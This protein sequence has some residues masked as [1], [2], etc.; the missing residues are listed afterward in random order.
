MRLAPGAIPFLRKACSTKELHVQQ[1]VATIKSTAIT[2]DDEKRDE[3]NRI[4]DIPGSPSS[5]ETR[6]STI[7]DTLSRSKPTSAYRRGP[8]ASELASETQEL[9]ESKLSPRNQEL[10]RLH[11]ATGG[12]SSSALSSSKSTLTALWSNIATSISS[13]FPSGWRDSFKNNAT[14]KTPAAQDSSTHEIN[15]SYPEKSGDQVEQ[16]FKDP[17]Q[18]VGDNEVWTFTFL[19][20]LI[21]PGP[22]LS[23]GPD[24]QSSNSNSN[25]SSSVSHDHDKHSTTSTSEPVMYA[26]TAIH[27]PPATSASRRRLISLDDD[28]ASPFNTQ[29]HALPPFSPRARTGSQQPRRRIGGSKLS[30]TMGDISHSHLSEP[31]TQSGDSQGVTHVTPSTPSF[32]RDSALAQVEALMST[33]SSVLTK[34]ETKGLQESS[35]ANRGTAV[36]PSLLLQYSRGSTSY[37]SSSSD[38]I[39]GARRSKAGSSGAGIRIQGPS[40][41]KSLNPWISESQDGDLLDANAAFEA[42]KIEEEH[43][44]RTAPR[45]GL[46]SRRSAKPREVGAATPLAALLRRRQRLREEAEQLEEQQNLD[47]IEAL[48]KE[49]EAILAADRQQVAAAAAAAAALHP[50]GDLRSDA[51]V[52][53]SL[54]QSSS[55]QDAVPHVDHQQADASTLHPPSGQRSI[56]EAM[57][58]FRAAL[59]ARPAPQSSTAPPAAKRRQRQVTA[60]VSLPH[61]GLEHGFGSAVAAG[62]AKPSSSQPEVSL[63]SGE[64]SMDEL[65]DMLDPTSTS[66]IQAAGAEVPGNAFFMDAQQQVPSSSSSSSSSMMYGDYNVNA[67]KA[68]RPY[69]DRRYDDNDASGRRYEKYEP[70]KR[71]PVLGSWMKGLQKKLSQTRHSDSSEGPSGG[72]NIISPESGNRDDQVWDKPDKFR[73]NEFDGSMVSSDDSRRSSRGRL[74]GEPRLSS[75]NGALPNFNNPDQVIIPSGTTLR[76]L[77]QLLN[78]SMDELEA[79]LTEQLGMSF[80]SHEEVV[81]QEAAELAAMEWGRIAIL[82]QGEDEARYPP[83]ARPPVVT[84]MGHVDHGKTSLLDALRNSN[85]AAS[86]AGGITQ[87]I[88]AFEV[89]LKNTSSGLAVGL[90]TSQQQSIGSSTPEDAS[91]PSTMAQPSDVITFLDTPGHAAFSS[92]RA[93]GAAL[94]DIVVLVVAADDGV[95]PQTREALAHARSAGCPLVVALTKCDLPQA[96][97]E[98]V[99][100]QLLEEGVELEEQGGTVQLVRT[101]AVSGLG[102][103]DLQEAL[104]LQAEIMELQSA[105]EGPATASVVEARLD[106]GAGAVATVVVRSG[107][108][109]V[110]DP[111]VVGT[112]WGRVRALKSGSGE[113]LEVVGPGRHAL[114]IGLKGLPMAGDELSVMGSEQRARSVALARAERAEDFRAARMAGSLHVQRMK[115]R[116]A[117][118]EATE[119]RRLLR[120][121]M[122]ALLVQNKQRTAQKLAALSEELR[123]KTSSSSTATISATSPQDSGDYVS[124]AAAAAS[125]VEGTAHRSASSDSVQKPPA[126][127]PDLIETEVP[128]VIKAD[129]QGSVE[130]LINA[131]KNL[132]IPGVSPRVLLSGVG[133]LTMSDVN[134][135][136]ASGA[137]II[138][139][140]QQSFQSKAVEASVQDLKKQGMSMIR[141][142]VIYHLLDQIRGVMEGAA[143]LIPTEEVVGRAVVQATFPL[144]TSK[145]RVEGGIAGVRVAAASGNSSAQYGHEGGGS[146]SSAGFGSQGLGGLVKDAAFYRVV[147]QDQ[148]IYQGPCTSL[149]RN[150]GDVESVAAG[151]EC[152]VV[153]GGGEFTGYLPNDVIECIRVLTKQQQ[154]A[155]A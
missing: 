53:P 108:L 102:L 45:T 77:S 94:T 16:S 11:G 78:S 135:A 24:S 99:I 111:V 21:K 83:S 48:M 121:Q 86:E 143:P 134:L 140:N 82:V 123:N 110:G 119:R 144:S 112:E 22:S 40:S 106:R 149:K 101:S 114:V 81:P 43:M 113:S 67:N 87:H 129:V 5:R 66:A 109:R 125:S 19:Q 132:G 32:M 118:Q 146:T 142:N 154:H 141:H 150:K 26:G 128:L 97:P 133:P 105:H 120:Q 69:S 57:E 28:K 64:L 30:L 27:L 38:G 107:K 76:G 3:I 151:L 10:E 50:A 52:P 116:V 89:T 153:L 93:R 136:L 55:T 155:S 130:A 90:S 51:G 36:R 103:S 152:G 41:S 49:Q 79:F 137:H 6:A 84:I 7:D 71:I 20:Q 138:M 60:A 131:L 122:R 63:R 95:M 33:E 147:R 117:S 1:L 34:G 59:A 126:T 68:Y 47:A 37:P 44:L 14:V 29:Q 39:Q 65:L 96:R 18:Q 35:G 31:L 100:G 25:S 127:P 61:P 80:K 88:G 15:T 92:M 139:F 85:V 23:S 9:L 12:R 74:F 115:E 75:G 13:L 58:S 70:V 62:E 73:S 148:V 17:A 8:S 104:L 56:F 124:A 54:P 2:C 72:D 46:L 98:R 91:A 4:D 145:G 42:A